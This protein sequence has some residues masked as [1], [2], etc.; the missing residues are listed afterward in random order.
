MD[1]AVPHLNG[2]VIPHVFP[3]LEATQE[4]NPA[5]APGRGVIVDE[6]PDSVEHADEPEAGGEQVEEQEDARGRCGV[7]QS[8]Q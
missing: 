3:G 4:G 1:N 2:E 5:A 8:I 6:P 7:T